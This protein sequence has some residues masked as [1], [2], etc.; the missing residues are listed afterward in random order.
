MTGPR[1]RRLGVVKEHLD[2]IPHLLSLPGR[3][4]SF[5]K[6]SRKRLKLFDREAV[7]IKASADAGTV[8]ENAPP[9]Y[10]TREVRRY[11]AIVSAP[12]FGADQSVDWGVH[13]IGCRESTGSASHFRFKYSQDGI[14]DHINEFG[15]IKDIN[16]IMRHVR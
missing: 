5:E 16:G 2:S 12:Y 4:T 11:V 13:C 1:A 15:N 14:Y 9:D 8:E 6:L 7:R 3:Y 10:K